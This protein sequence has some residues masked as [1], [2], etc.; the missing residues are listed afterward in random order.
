MPTLDN[1]RELVNECSMTWCSLGN[2]RR[3]ILVTGPNGNK[4][5]LPVT[6]YYKDS[7]IRDD[8]FQAYYWTSSLYKDNPERAWAIFLGEEDDEKESV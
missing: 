6:G 1:F 3:A 4:I 8:R 7:E 5:V 2:R